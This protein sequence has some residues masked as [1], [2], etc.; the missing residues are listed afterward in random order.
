M[1]CKVLIYFDQ[2]IDLQYLPERRTIAL[3]ENRGNSCWSADWPTWLRGELPA[4]PAQRWGGGGG[5]Q[6]LISWLTYLAERRATSTP[7]TEMGWGGGG[8]TAVDQ[9]I[10]LLGWDQ[11]YQHP[12]KGDCV[13]WEYLRHIRPQDSVVAEGLVNKLKKNTKLTSWTWQYEYE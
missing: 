8:R 5:E 4:P 10:D 2:L 9:L 1:N 11:S 3:W 13:G 12:Q 7:S 6:R